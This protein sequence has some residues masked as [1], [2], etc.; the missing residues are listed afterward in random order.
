MNVRFCSCCFG[1]AEN[2]FFLGGVLGLTTRMHDTHYTS[3]LEAGLAFGIHLVHPI[4]NQM[5]R[6]RVVDVQE[7][8][9]KNSAVDTI[10]MVG[11]TRSTYTTTLSSPSSPT[12][13][14]T[15]P[16][17]LQSP[18]ALVAHRT[19]SLF[20]PSSFFLLLSLVIPF[21][22]RF[23][24]FFPFSLAALPP[25]SLNEAAPGCGCTCTHIALGPGVDWVGVQGADWA[26][27]KVRCGGA[28][29]CDRDACRSIGPRCDAAHRRRGDTIRW[30][31][32]RRCRGARGGGCGRDACRSIGRSAMRCDAAR[33]RRGDETRYEWSPLVDAEG[34]A[35]GG[36]GQTSRWPVAGGAS[37]SET[38]AEQAVDR[39]MGCASGAFA[40]GPVEK[41]RVRC[42]VSLL[43][44]G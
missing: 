37:A 44:I 19:V 1:F 14:L 23:S 16:Q 5:S 30:S 31:P 3:G 11:I 26:G 9:Y 35:R 33:R 18:S 34:R 2:G 42:S 27:C 40:F 41:V 4:P 43:H 7:N 13:A 8:E 32:A 28:G 6:S 10:E 21:V 36:C 29:G 12:P 25:L 24:F 22:L 17:G 38:A 15:N 20:L 39:S